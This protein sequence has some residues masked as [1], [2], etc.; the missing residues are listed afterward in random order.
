[1][2]SIL[3]LA[4]FFVI[5]KLSRT[6]AVL[7]GGNFRNCRLKSDKLVD[8][9]ILRMFLHIETFGL[10]IEQNHLMQILLYVPFKLNFKAC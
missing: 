6:G 3:K 9:N 5:L 1:M 7:S 2:Q 4:P 10:D 8:V